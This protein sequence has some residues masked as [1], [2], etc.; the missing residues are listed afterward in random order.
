VR[1]QYAHCILQFAAPA[2][3]SP[4]PSEGPESSP[5]RPFEA[6]YVRSQKTSP[7]PIIGVFWHRMLLPRGAGTEP[8]ARQRP[9]TA[10]K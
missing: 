1:P 4:R 9:A 6:H 2:P 7:L 3:A 10:T 8:Q 5:Q